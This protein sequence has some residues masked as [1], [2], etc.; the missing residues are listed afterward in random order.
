VAR[1]GS[2]GCRH[3]GEHVVQQAVRRDP[4]ELELG[5]HQ[6]S[7]TQGG[8]EFSSLELTELARE[9]CRDWVPKALERGMELAFDAPA[10]PLRVSGNE[11][12]L[13]ELLNNLLDNAVRYG[14][15]GGHIFVKL[16][17]RP[18]P[19]LVVEDDGPGIRTTEADKMF[20]RFYRIPGSPGDGCGL[21]LAIVKE[22][23][24]LHHAQVRIGVGRNAQGTLVE[25]AFE[26]VN[27]E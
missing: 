2:A 8:R 25:V 10:E 14:R 16:R 4:L 12:L 22:I 20:E 5:P 21:G 24:D 23:A 26:A 15:E 17:N 27:V 18:R 19:T 6:E 13:R 7:V 11:T 1:P 3:G 9:C